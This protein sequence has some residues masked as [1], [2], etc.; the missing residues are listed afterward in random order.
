MCFALKQ[1]G[2]VGRG[3]LHRSNTTLLTIRLYLVRSTG[4]AQIQIIHSN[5]AQVARCADTFEGHTA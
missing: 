5:A 2:G 1:P 4:F 3:A